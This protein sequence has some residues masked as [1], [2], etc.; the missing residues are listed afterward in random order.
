MIF[1]LSPAKASVVAIGGTSVQIADATMGSKGGLIVNGFTADDQELTSAESLFVNLLGPAGLVPGPGTVEIVPG[2]A[3]LVPPLVNVWVNAASTGHKFTAFF[4]APYAPLYPPHPVP[5]QPGG[6]GLP[7]GTAGAFPPIGP[8]GLLKVIP[9]YLYQEY[10]DDDD[11]QAF[12]AA[13]NSKQQDYVDTFNALNLPIYTGPLVAGAL[14]DWVG[15]GLYGYPRPALSTGQPRTVGPLNTWGPAM[16]PE[17]NDMDVLTPYAVVVT[18]DDTYRRC[19]T[20]HFYKSDGK[21]FDTRWL[22]RRVWRFCYGVNGTAPDAV[23]EGAPTPSIADTEQISISLGVHKNVTIRFVLGQRK[24]MGGA[25]VNKFGCNGF[26]PLTPDVD[27]FASIAL[28][29]L[30]TSYTPLPP[31]PFMRVFQEALASGVLETPVP[32][33]FTVTIG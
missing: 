32:W 5:G 20:W 2:E 15:S 25:I 19:L 6:P 28:N 21:Y 10:S 18:N 22:K 29:D 16:L 23:P 3:F 27:E 7:G 9:S 8:T 4:S 17:I 1:I 13:Q 14:L 31:I 12:V 33:N 11:L 24:V 30:E 26:G